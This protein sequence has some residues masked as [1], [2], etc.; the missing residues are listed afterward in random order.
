MEFR[1][2]IFY[3][4]SYNIGGGELLFL[5][6]AN[7]FARYTKYDVYFVDYKDGY[8]S[9]TGRL[10]T[11]IKVFVKQPYKCL[12]P[13][14]SIVIIQAN[15]VSD[16]N[17]FFEVDRSRV[18]F[19]LWSLH[20]GNFSHQLQFN[21]RFLVPKFYRH[22]IGKH[23]ETLTNLQ[24]INYMSIQGYLDTV[25]GFGMS[26]NTNSIL[27][28]LID[29]N[30]ICIPDTYKTIEGDTCIHFAWLGRLDNVNA[31]T[32]ETYMN[33]LGS[34]YDRGLCLELS[35][36]GDGVALQELKD[37]STRFG[38]KTN[39][40]GRV[41]FED[42]S[43]Y[44]KKVHVGLASGTSAYEFSVR[45]TPVVILWR[46]DRTYAA[47]ERNDFHLQHEADDCEIIDD[48]YKWRR[49]GLFR[50]KVMELLLNYQAISELG[51]EYIINNHTI[52][53]VCNEIENIG[54]VLINEDYSVQYH[55]IDKASCLIN[56]PKMLVVRNAYRIAKL[57]KMIIQ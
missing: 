24:V 15:H 5:R 39:F 48:S 13:Q 44:I 30:N 3:Y 19:L 26:C 57:I 10:E 35:I 42:L 37:Y 27:P 50:D 12:I 33:E 47:G 11:N 40:V 32:I 9:S 54:R 34:L 4:P 29:V 45:K 31:R 20:E 16:I 38:Y 6:C 17:H 53:K 22:R 25:R 14:D 49:Q 46:I 23:L 7:Y 36:I 2:I 41:A 21:S 8:I 43:E 18:R 1:N 28:N 56:V 55:N 51:Y 52:D